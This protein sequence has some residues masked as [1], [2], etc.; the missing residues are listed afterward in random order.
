MLHSPAV[1]AVVA[2]VIKMLLFC[3]F[4]VAAFVVSVLLLL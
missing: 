1:H 4:I 2:V 3:K